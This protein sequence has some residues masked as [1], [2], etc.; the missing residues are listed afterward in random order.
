MRLR[1]LW[2]ALAACLLFLTTTSVARASSM[3]CVVRVGRPIDDALL[4]R[5]LGQTSDLPLAIVRVPGPIEAELEAAQRRA[6]ELA[7][8]HG[9]RAIVWFAVEARGDVTIYVVDPDARRRFVHRVGHDVGSPSAILETSGLIVRDVLKALLDGEPIGVPLEIP[10][11]GPDEALRP[12]LRIAL[13]PAREPPIAIA[14]RPPPTW[15]PF[16]AL[17]ARAVLSN[18]TP[19]FALDHRIGLTRTNLEL[20][21]ALTLGAEDMRTDR[22]ASLLLR[23]HTVGLFGGWRWKLG[24]EVTA[25]AGV[26]SGLALFFRSTRP[27]V[28]SLAATPSQTTVNG[29]VGPEVR[30]SWAPRRSWLRV[31]LGAGGDVVFAPPAFSYEDERGR[32]V[33]KLVLWPVQ[34]HVTVSLELT[35]GP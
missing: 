9:A 7:R 18:V 26:S 34:P 8:S 12:P 19:S 28:S 13:E 11:P 30:L 27:E 22:L 31:S 15:V 5:V 33:S 25:T 35:P 10:S 6:D 17:G 23:R 21:V 1:G 20:G 16:T 3:V 29:F 4:K 32:T 24:D 2:M 14:A